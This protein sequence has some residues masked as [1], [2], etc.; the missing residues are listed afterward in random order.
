MRHTDDQVRSMMYERLADKSTSCILCER[1]DKHSIALVSDIYYVSSLLVIKAL[2]SAMF[3]D[4]AN[5][6]NNVGLG[7]HVSKI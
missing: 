7:P 6:R 1:I 4:Q 2:I 5:M 3:M